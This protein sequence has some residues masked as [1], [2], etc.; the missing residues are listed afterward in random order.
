MIIT[1]S[2]DVSASESLVFER[3][4]EEP[5]A[6]DLES[7]EGLLG[8]ENAVWMFVDGE[9]AGECFGMAVNCLGSDGAD[10]TNYRPYKRDSVYC[11]GTTILPKFQG[12]GLAKLLVAYWNGMMRGLGYERVIGHATSDKMVAVRKGLGAKFD[13]DQVHEKW[14]GTERTAHFYVQHL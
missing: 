6:C 7:K 11:Y 2:T 8:W 5:L 10:P 3:T 9:L 14:Y 4:Y 12:L 13:P 1:F